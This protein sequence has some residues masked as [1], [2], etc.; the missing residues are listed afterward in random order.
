MNKTIPL[1]RIDELR[2]QPDADCIAYTVYGFDAIIKRYASRKAL[3]TFCKAGSA[4]Y[5]L[6]KTP[7]H[8]SMLVNRNTQRVAA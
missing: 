1:G 6:I 4:H 8:Q 2:S 7:V 3:E 5:A